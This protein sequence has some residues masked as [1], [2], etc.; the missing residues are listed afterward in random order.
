MK[1]FS[2]RKE[3]GRLQEILPAVKMFLQDSSAGSAWT[4]GLALIYSELGME[5]EARTEFEK[6]AQDDFDSVPQDALTAL[7]LVYLAEVCAFLGDAGRAKVLYQRLLPWDGQ[8]VVVP[9]G[10]AY[11]GSAPRYLGLLAATMGLWE[12][13]ESHFLTAA[14]MDAA[15]EATTW[16]SHTQHDYAKMLL[17]RNGPGDREQAV[18]LIE[19]ATLACQAS[20]MRTLE[21]RLAGL[22]ALVDAGPEKRPAYPAGLTAREVDVIKLVATGMTDREIA[23]DLFIS[24]GTV[25]THV[26]NILNKTGSVNRTEAAAYAIRN[27]LT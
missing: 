9:G 18:S 5:S 21:E 1:M 27:G 2:I 14:Q 17:S 12:A 23:G 4:P 15:M 7:C 25:N 24:V 13:A 22:K 11:Y 3:Q 16:L 20:G 10:V 6:L 8:N 26:K 19:E